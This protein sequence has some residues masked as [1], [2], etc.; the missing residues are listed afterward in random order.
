[1]SSP[2]SSGGSSSSS[3][4]LSNSDSSS[5]D[6]SSSS[7]T[8]SSESEIDFSDTELLDVQ[9][10][11]KRVYVVEVD[12]ETDE[13][14]MESVMLIIHMTACRCATQRAFLLLLTLS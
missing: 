14:I 13:D 1:M 12:D 8:S 7:T 9:D 6:S 3:D 5:Y 11:G 4:S 10:D 2:S